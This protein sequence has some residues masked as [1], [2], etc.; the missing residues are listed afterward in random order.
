VLAALCGWLEAW[1]ASLAG[2]GLTPDQIGAFLNAKSEFWLFQVEKLVKL[3]E[4][5]DLEV[6]G[7]AAGGAF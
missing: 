3:A 4:H 6:R 1:A 7:L 2:A 5:P